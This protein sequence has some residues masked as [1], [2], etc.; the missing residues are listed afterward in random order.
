MVQK[1][2]I[3]SMENR[4][5]AVLWLDT[6]IKRKKWNKLKFINDFGVFLSS[7]YAL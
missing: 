5:A 2:D 1:S 7:I 4:P 6:Q 3:V